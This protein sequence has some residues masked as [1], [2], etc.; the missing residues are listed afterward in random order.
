MIAKQTIMC[1]I[2]LTDKDNK[3]K[4]VITM[5]VKEKTRKK[6]RNIALIGALADAVMVLAA[7]GFVKS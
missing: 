1:Y 6:W 5:T 3:K 7:I 4:G 2:M